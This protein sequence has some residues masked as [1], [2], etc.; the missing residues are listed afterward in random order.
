MRGHLHLFHGLLTLD[1]GLSS[2]E[3]RLELNTER[4]LWVALLVLSA[5]DGNPVL[6]VGFKWGLPI[7]VPHPLAMVIGSAMST[8]THH[9]QRLLPRVFPT[10]AL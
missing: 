3:N 7:T 10:R 8:L 6:L 4:D 5:W 9:C 1:S 2:G